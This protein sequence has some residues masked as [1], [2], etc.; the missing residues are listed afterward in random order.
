MHQIVKGGSGSNRAFHQGY[1]SWL[2]FEG[3]KNWRKKKLRN[4]K[5][6]KIWKLICVTENTY[7]HNL[8]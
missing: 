3:Q 7:E 2:P 6:W 1:Q 8:I 5:C 4:E